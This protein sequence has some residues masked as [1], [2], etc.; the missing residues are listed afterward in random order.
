MA[1]TAADMV[2][3]H[4]RESAKGNPY[5]SNLSDDFQ[6]FV[7]GRLR[8]GLPSMANDYFGLFGGG[9]DPDVKG[10]DTDADEWSSTHGARTNFLGEDISKPYENQALGDIP[11]SRW[12]AEQFV[13]SYPEDIYS[14]FEYGGMGPGLATIPLGFLGSGSTS[15]DPFEENP[16]RP[17][18]RKVKI[19][20]TKGSGNTS[21]GN[22]GNVIN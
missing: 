10:W 18:K 9:Y 1:R 4:D 16:Y 22:F 11:Y 2:G 8:P 15:F 21:P 14:A 5:E 13:P 12:I 17:P 7:R 6:R 20:K 19:D 3:I